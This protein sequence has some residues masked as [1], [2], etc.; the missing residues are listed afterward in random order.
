MAETCPKCEYAGIKGDTCPRCRVIVSHYRAYLVG[1][2][3]KRSRA[4]LQRIR[5][6]PLRWV[7]LFI[8]VLGINI[9]VLFGTMP[10]RPLE[11][12]QLE[13][14]W[15]ALGERQVQW[16][17]VTVM[18][19]GAAVVVRNGILAGA[20]C[21]SIYAAERMGRYSAL[22]IIF[23][24][25]EKGE[26]GA[27]EVLGPLVFSVCI[28]VITYRTW[29]AWREENPSSWPRTV[30]DL[31]FI[32]VVFVGL[33]SVILMAAIGRARLVALGLFAF[34]A[35]SIFG[36]RRVWKTGEMILRAPW[37]AR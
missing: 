21:S 1:R 15:Q 8:I 2:R 27:L 30:L 3:E 7:V 19:C 29:R 10:P 28:V 31:M 16:F 35:V 12:D 20:F 13:Q 4:R 22:D 17:W 9:Y 25:I 26:A 23:T 18:G 33:P 34:A 37:K 14:W 24:H 5:E 6:G 36:L 32:S 11:R